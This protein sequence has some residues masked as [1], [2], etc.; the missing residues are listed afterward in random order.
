MVKLRVLA[1]VFNATQRL[2]RKKI[3][4]EGGLMM[5]SDDQNRRYIRDRPLKIQLAA[6][7]LYRMR[8]SLAAAWFGVQWEDETA[9]LD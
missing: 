8:A 7:T 9:P 5:N 3:S 2:L 6:R 1:L 4:Q